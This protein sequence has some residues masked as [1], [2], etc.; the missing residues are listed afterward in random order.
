MNGILLYTRE[1]VKMVLVAN[2]EGAQQILGTGT[3]KSQAG[4]P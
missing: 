4:F 3:N 1:G 2:Y